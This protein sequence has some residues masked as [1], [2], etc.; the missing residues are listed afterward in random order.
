MEEENFKDSVRSYYESSLGIDDPFLKDKQGRK[1]YYPAG[2]FGKGYYIPDSAKAEEISKFRQASSGICMAV[3]GIG[4]LLAGFGNPLVW[5]LVFVIL[6]ILWLWSRI[7]MRK[8]L[9]GLE[10]IEI[11]SANYSPQN[12]DKRYRWLFVTILA[13]GIVGGIGNIYNKGFSIN[14]L[15]LAVSSAFFLVAYSYVTWIRK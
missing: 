3:G 11:G 5:I 2:P 7:T 9:A 12:I 15:I 10:V 6:L 13:V 8:I 14:D 1:T 4:I